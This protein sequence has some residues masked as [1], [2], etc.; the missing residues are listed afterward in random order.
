MQGE[1]DFN[2]N[3]VECNPSTYQYVICVITPLGPWLSFDCGSGPKT[4]W[5][6]DAAGDRGQLGTGKVLPVNL[7]EPKVS[8]T[9][10]ER[11][12]GSRGWEMGP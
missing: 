12:A 2:A 3:T 10:L 9:A 11:K 5:V 1:G 7:V 8:K 6:A 4:K